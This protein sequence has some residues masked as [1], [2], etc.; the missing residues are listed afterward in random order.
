MSRRIDEAIVIEDD[1]L[2]RGA[3]AHGAGQLSDPHVFHENMVQ[4]REVPH[5]VWEPSQSWIVT[6]MEQTQGL[7]SPNLVRE[8]KKTIVIESQFF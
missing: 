5:R 2:Q 3:S 7:T 4:E 8:T 6:Q 1:E